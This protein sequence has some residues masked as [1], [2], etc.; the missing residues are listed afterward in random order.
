MVAIETVEVTLTLSGYLATFNQTDF[1]Q[2]LATS[3]GI[4]VSAIRLTVQ[5]GA[6][7]V[8]TSLRNRAKSSLSATTALLPRRGGRK[9]SYTTLQT[10][11]LRS[12]DVWVHS[13][14]R[15]NIT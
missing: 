12:M 3:L 7:V 15:C 4:P 13:D 2:S 10:I 14:I 1:K 5:S 6:V 8:A 11:Q 9:S